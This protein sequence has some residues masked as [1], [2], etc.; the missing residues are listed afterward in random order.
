MKLIAIE[1][2]FLTPK[3]PERLVLKCRGD[4]GTLT[5]NAGPVG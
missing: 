5:L 3:V 1:D 2:H 4:V